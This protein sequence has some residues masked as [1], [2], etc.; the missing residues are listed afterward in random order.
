MGKGAGVG[1]RGALGPAGVGLGDSKESGAA[2]G[3]D[4]NEKGDVGGNSVGMV[5]EEGLVRGGV[6]IGDAVGG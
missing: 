1:R 2:E 3:R 5:L 4:R 6:G